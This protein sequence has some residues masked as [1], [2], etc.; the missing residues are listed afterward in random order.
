MQNQ[1]KKP[2]L[3]QKYI[4]QKFVTNTTK[5][6]PNKIRLFQFFKPYTS[7]E[8]LHNQ[9]TLKGHSQLPKGTKNDPQDLSRSL[10][11]TKTHITD[12][13]LCNDF[14]HFGTFTFNKRKID[15]YNDEE[16]RK[17]LAKW[18]NNQQ[19]ITNGF[20]YL[21]IPERHKDGALH[22][23]ALLKGYPTDKFTESGRKD[24][25]GRKIYNLPAFSLGFTNFTS[26]GHLGKTA[27]YV[28]KYV[29]KANTTDTNKK[30]YWASKNLKTPK[31][32]HNVDAV[33][34]KKTQPPDRQEIVWANDLFYMTDI[35]KDNS[36]TIKQHVATKALNRKRLSG[37]IPTA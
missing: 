1:P 26:I 31:M 33:Q 34:L 4:S 36:L 21:L 22:Y 16:V 30:R 8:S 24:K 19:R 18:L 7:T 15:R 6:Y 28:Q 29:T 13:I 35:Y 23:H 9:S 5:E 12:L 3:S 17:K 27:T 32:C 10:R 25:S 11:R 2:R 37:I 20:E 14:T